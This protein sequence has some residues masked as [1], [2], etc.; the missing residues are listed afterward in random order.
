MPWPRRIPPEVS[1]R[2]GADSAAHPLSR[3]PEHMSK[4]PTDELRC[5][6]RCDQERDQKCDRSRYSRR[7]HGR[8]PQ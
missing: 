7:P 5:A 1:S 8:L 6:Q 3:R 2:R 4:A